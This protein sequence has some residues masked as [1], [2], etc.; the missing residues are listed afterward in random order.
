M[1][2]DE[3]S[4][5][6][7]ADRKTLEDIKVEWDQVADI[8]RRQLAEGKDLSFDQVLT[9]SVLELLADCDRRKVVDLGCGTGALT[10][11]IASQ[12]SNVVGVDLSTRSIALARQDFGH[13]GNME[14]YAGTAEEFADE[15]DKPDFTAAV[16]AM[17]LMDCLDLSSFV[18]ATARLI[19]PGGHFVVTITHPYFWPRYWGYDSA[20]WFNYHDERVIEN[21]FRISNETSDHITTHVHRPLSSYVNSLSD[22]RFSIDRMIEP[23]PDEHDRERFPVPWTFPRFLA[24]RA[25]KIT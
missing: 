3:T 11:K 7:P 20:D 1:H 18:D 16:A 17:T 10:E 14:F 22:T 15:R 19:V 2:D 5:P 24:F 9:P 25:Q 4:V 12:S 8:R 6:V 13:H 21:R 23:F